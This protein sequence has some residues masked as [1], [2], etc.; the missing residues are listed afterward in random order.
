[1]VRFKYKSVPDKAAYTYQRKT[2]LPPGCIYNPDGVACDPK[3]HNCQ[4]C[5]HNPVVAAN[6]LKK[7][8]RT[9]ARYK[10]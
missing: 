5:G 7:L 4:S 1:M 6:R 9:I 8:Y 2:A 10:S 3:E